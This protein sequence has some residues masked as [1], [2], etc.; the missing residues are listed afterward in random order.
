MLRAV[1][2]VAGA[3][4]LMS[5]HK[6]LTRSWF[7][8]RDSNPLFR[9]RIPQEARQAGLFDIDNLLGT[10]ALRLNSRYG[11]SNHRPEMLSP[12]ESFLSKPSP[13]K[14]LVSIGVLV[15]SRFND[16][17]VCENVRSFNDRTVSSV[18]DRGIEWFSR[19]R[20]NFAAPRGI[21]SSKEPDLLSTLFEM[22]IEIFEDE[23]K[24]CFEGRSSSRQKIWIDVCPRQIN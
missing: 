14:V 18:H 7:T 13:T 8:T 10:I 1:F 24:L 9:S 2:C 5:R 20:W 22:T 17:L 23:A 19:S 6:D 4:A 11:E 15:K 16:I 21:E 12:E 3:R